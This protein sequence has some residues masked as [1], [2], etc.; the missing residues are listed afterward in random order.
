MDATVL[1]SGKVYNLSIIDIVSSCHASSGLG[2][3]L[4][5]I[6]TSKM[7]KPKAESQRNDLTMPN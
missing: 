6:V 2:T 7:K 1:T 4:E 5:A 3:G